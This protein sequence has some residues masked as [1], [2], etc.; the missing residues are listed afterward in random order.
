MFFNKKK[1]DF[2]F[3]LGEACSST[4]AL[5]KNELQIISNPFDW[6]G[7]PTLE[8]RIDFILNDFENFLNIEDLE[9]LNCTNN[10]A[11]CLCDVYHNK[12][13]EFIFNHD[14]PAGIK[15]EDSF[16]KVKEKYNRR[17][18][19]LYEKINE[20]KNV[21]ILYVEV[22]FNEEK[23]KDNNRLIDGLE[24]LKTK[25]PN[26]K[27]DFLYIINDTSFKPIKYKK[28]IITD[29]ITKISGNYN[30]LDESLPIHEINHK[31]FKK[32]LRN[33]QLKLPISYFI[34]KFAIRF[35]IMFIPNRDTRIKL[36]KKYHV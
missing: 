27:F 23:L 19:R 29:E 6:I 1:Y 15:L 17:I 20:S 16:D 24:K 9:S 26:T 36:R 34:R 10:L 30:R 18:K 32:I 12:K 5:R 33:Y 7:G 4:E 13:N 8:E 2:I 22:P 31:F 11:D 25:F 35:Y 21:L 28:E 3:S 14:F